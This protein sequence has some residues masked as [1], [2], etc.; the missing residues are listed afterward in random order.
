MMAE[1]G[2]GMERHP[3][4]TIEEIEQRWPDEWVL[5]EVTHME[6]YQAVAGRVIGHGSDQE[7]DYL[8][9]QELALHQQ[10]PDAET[11]LFWTGEPIPEDMVVV[12]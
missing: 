9:S 1:E 7:I 5:I 10:H 11:Y 2:D 3:D 6:N 4:M 12:L 8:V